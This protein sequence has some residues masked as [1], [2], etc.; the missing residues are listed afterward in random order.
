L[1]REDGQTIGVMEHWVWAGIS[2]GVA[3][4]AADVGGATALGRA[5]GGRG[6]SLQCAEL[7][8]QQLSLWLDGDVLRG[9]HPLLQAMSDLDAAADADAHEDE[10]PCPHADPDA[11]AHP[12]PYTNA[13]E[14]AEAADGNRHAQSH[15]D[16]Y[17]HTYLYT[18]TNIY[19][20]IIL[21]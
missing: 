2:A 15:A 5:R 16:V 7:L 18:D 13:D 9:K 10:H 1:R 17:L 3:D 20:D 11:D 14:H 6:G 12:Q 21:F 8:R 19:P 4:G